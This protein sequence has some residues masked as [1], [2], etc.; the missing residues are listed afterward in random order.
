MIIDGRLKILL[1]LLMTYLLAQ[2]GVRATMLLMTDSV[3]L[4]STELLKMFGLGLIY[5]LTAWSLMSI[6][7]TLILSLRR[8]RL[9]KIS[10]FFFDFMTVLIAVALVLFFREFGTNFN[11]IAVDYLIYTHELLGNIWQSFNIPLIIITI[12]LLTTLIYILQEKIVPLGFDRRSGRKNFNTSS[13]SIWIIVFVPLILVPIVQSS[14]RDS[15]SDN[16]YNVEIAGNGYYEFVCAYFTNELDYETFYMTKDNINFNPETQV[17]NLNELSNIKPNV[18]MITV[19]SLNAEYMSIFGGTGLTPRLDNLVDESYIFTR[20]YATGTRT[21]RGLE[22][23]TLS[24]PPTPGQSIVRRENND[25]LSC[26]GDA[27]KQNGYERDFIYGGYGYFDN[28]NAFFAGNGY[29]VKDRTD[30]SDNEIVHETIWGVADE[31]LFTQVLK[32]MDEHYS[33]GNKAFEMVM[34]TSNHRPFTFPEGRIEMP[35]GTRPAAVKYTDWAIGDF[36]ERASTKPW[37]NDTIFVII[38]DHQALAAGKSTLPINCYHIPCLIYAPNLISPGKCER[39]IS[40]IDLAPTL[41]GM[42]GLSYSEKFLG[43]DINKVNESDDRVFISTYQMLGYIKNDTLI[44]L[45][46]D[47]KAVAY[48]INDWDT[49]DYTAI[50][51]DSVLL[52]EAINYYQGAA[53]LFKSGQLKLSAR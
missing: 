43:H 30:I 6:P 25:N 36:L 22:A 51:V 40:Q 34:T 35:D 9:I 17:D 15:V 11:F 28:M 8:N 31:V 3:S 52:D 38:A 48:R 44:V 47:K 26:L 50:E 39:L 13:G 23:L 41:L 21:V 24:L 14:W 20:M 1:T 27:F 16:R 4:S 12:L 10:V 53:E 19:E 46:P 7:L 45:T 18:I 33:K 5:D 2:I 32:S 29:T 49:S 42:L 37:F